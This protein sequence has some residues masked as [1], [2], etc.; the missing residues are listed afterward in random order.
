MRA[1]IKAMNAT[2]VGLVLVPT[3]EKRERCMKVR[4]CKALRVAAV[5]VSG[6]DASGTWKIRA[7]KSGQ[8]IDEHAAVACTSFR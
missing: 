2:A 1:G 5:C 7:R 8:E 6:G 3:G 4:C